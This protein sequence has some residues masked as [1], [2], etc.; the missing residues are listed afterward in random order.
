M[1]NLCN[2][3]FL[4]NRSPGRQV[5]RNCFDNFSQFQIP[6]TTLFGKGNAG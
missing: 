5:T 4:K 3:R 1:R 6:Y 2:L